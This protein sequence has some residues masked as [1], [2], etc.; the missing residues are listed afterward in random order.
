MRAFDMD[1]RPIAVEDSASELKIGLGYDAVGNVAT[2]TSKTY[3]AA[4]TYDALARL[5]EFR[6]AV[7]NVAVEQYSYDATGNRLSFSNA[8]GTD[9][10]TYAVSSHQLTNVAD[11]SRTY[12]AIGNTTAVGSAG[13]GLVYN[14]ANRLSQ[15]TQGGIV[16]QRYDYNA[17]G[18]RVRRGL[19]ATASMY[20]IYDENGRWLGEYTALGATSQ[21]VIW[22][23]DMPVGL[24]TAG[25]LHYI[26]PDHLGTPRLVFNPMRNVPVWTWDIKGEAFGR[27]APNEDPD[28]DETPF[29]FDMRFPGQRFDLASGL[30]YNYFRD[31]DPSTGRYVQS[32]PIGL[33]GGISTY[34]YVGGKPLDAI[35]PLGLVDPLRGYNPAYGPIIIRTQ[36]KQIGWAEKFV[37]SYIVGKLTLGTTSVGKYGH[38]TPRASTL[39]GRAGVFVALMEPVEVD[40]SDIDCDGDGFA[41][42]V[43]RQDPEVCPLPN[44]GLLPF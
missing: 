19:N 39:I 26:E 11:T 41:D 38:L 35:D 12:D 2:L 9:A 24:L 42:F 32:D 23:D 20:A 36:L 40:C 13:K 37:S 18:Q 6:D 1:Y 16:A 21:E 27:D 31:Y 5:T 15:I 33:E 43:Q 3:Q 7:A 44:R 28:L 8:G 30:N 34:G 14:Q 29:V 25:V 22:M 4:L 10:Y 17:L